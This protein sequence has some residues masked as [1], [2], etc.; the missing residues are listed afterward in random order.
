MASLQQLFARHSVHSM[1]HLVSATGEAS[2]LTAQFQL[3]VVPQTRLMAVE[4]TDVLFRRSKVFRGLL[5]PRL[6]AFL[7]SLPQ[8]SRLGPL[9]ESPCIHDGVW[10]ARS[11]LK[12]HSRGVHL[13]LEAAR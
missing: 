6:A 4:L 11:A 10:S 12:A 13:G 9:L 8:N 7:V 3:G 2:S 1:P 5:A